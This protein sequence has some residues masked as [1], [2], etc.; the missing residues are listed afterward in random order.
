V[1][2]S[3]SSATP[4]DHADRGTVSLTAEDRVV[5][6]LA[7]V[8]DVL[9]APE[10][11][12]E[13]LD[14]DERGTRR[15]ATDLVLGVGSERPVTFRRSMIVT[16]GPARH[17]SHGWTIPIEWQAAALTPLFPV[18]VGRVRVESERVAIDGYYAP[19]FGIIGVAIDRALLGIAARATTKVVLGRFARAM[20][21]T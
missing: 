9:D 17:E 18:F 3:R 8:P 2:A 5:V 14:H 1:T 13:E 20:R 12:G 15:F 19:P 11:L 4:G 16:L 21:R 7:R 10:W 6:D